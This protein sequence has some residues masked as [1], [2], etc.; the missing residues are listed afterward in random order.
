MDSVVF[1]PK[2]GK[3]WLNRLPT[4]ARDSGLSRFDFLYTSSG[5]GASLTMHP[6]LAGARKTAWEATSGTA[7]AHLLMSGRARQRHTGLLR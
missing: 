4:A 5:A 7:P 1:F 6:F 2:A 3:R